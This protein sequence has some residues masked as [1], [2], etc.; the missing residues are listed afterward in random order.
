M[1]SA[2]HA[3]HPLAEDA[4]D[5]AG[6][7]CAEALLQGSSS[8]SAS[9][10]R[11]RRSRANAGNLQIMETGIDTGALGRQLIDTFGKGWAKGNIALLLSVFTEDATFVESPFSEPHRGK[12]AIGKYWLETPYH[13]SEATFTSGEIYVAGPWFGTEF[14]CVFRLRR[15]G[16]WADVRGSIF[17][18]TQ[19]ELISEMRMCWER[20][21]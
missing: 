21:G 5:A 11:A 9:G 19:G 14:K 6:Q 10:A 12:E 3:S 4:P 2:R 7:P 13:Q 15:S 17:C 1:E 8:A 16:Q 18:E 20:R